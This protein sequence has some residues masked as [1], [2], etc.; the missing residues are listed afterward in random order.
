MRCAGAAACGNPLPAAS[1]RVPR[2]HRDDD[3]QLRRHDVQP[4]GAVLA[5]ADHLPA[6]AGTPR[7]VRFDDVLDPLQALRQMPEVAPRGTAPVAGGCP[8]A[9]DGSHRLLDLGH[10]ALQVL[11]RQ[12]AIIQGALLRALV[13]SLTS[14][15]RQDRDLS[16]ILS[17]KSASYKRISARKR[18]DIN[19][20]AAVSGAVSQA[21]VLGL[22]A[23]GDQAR[24]VRRFLRFPRFLATGAAPLA[25][26]AGP[27]A[28][29]LASTSRSLIEQ[30]PI[31][32]KESSKLIGSLN[33]R[34]GPHSAY[35]PVQVR[36]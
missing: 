8:R 25:A 33:G 19:A 2:A 36:P 6:P 30:L 26:A 17:M 20:C 13:L 11:E 16:H 12:L 31:Y 1:A 15:D 28:S 27:E 18:A 14:S 4:L 23:L 29:P 7:A 9:G 22:R 21:A 10:R 35:H 5:D 3:P 24:R 34:W 32:I